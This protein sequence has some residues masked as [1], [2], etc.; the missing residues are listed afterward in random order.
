VKDIVETIAIIGHSFRAAGLERPAVIMLASHEDGIKLIH[1][2]R[3]EM[4]IT[5]TIGDPRSPFGETVRMADGQMY[6]EVQILGMKIRW[7]A[8]CHATPDG[9]YIWI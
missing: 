5:Y 7:P 2:L 4:T 8:D 1:A 6:K 9:K 3:D